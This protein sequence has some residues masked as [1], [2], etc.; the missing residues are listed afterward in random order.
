MNWTR[1]T[2]G[3]S[4]VGTGPTGAYEGNYYMY[5]ET[6]GFNNKTAV[7]ETPQFNLDTIYN[8]MVSFYYHMYGATMGDL[9]F[10]VLDN[11]A[12]VTLWSMTGEQQTA[13]ADPWRE[14]I[15]D[16]SAYQTDTTQFR[17][18]GETGTSYT[19]D[20][21]IDDFKLGGPVL[22]TKDIGVDQ[23]LN[24][25][26][27]VMAGTAMPVQLTFSNFGSDTITTAT[28]AW[29]YD[30]TLQTPY[31]YTGSLIQGAQTASMTV[32]NPTP[33]LGSHTIKAWTENPN[34]TPD[35]NFGNDSMEVTFYACANLLSGT[36]TI[37]PN[38][39]GT[40]NYTSFADAALA[41]NQC[42]INGAVT[43]NVASG[44]YNEQIKLMPIN[45]SSATNTIT[46]QSASGD[47][48]L[49]TLK[50]NANA[51]AD[52]Y[53]IDLDG[54]AYIE[55]KDMT[56]EA[57]DTIFSNVFVLENTVHDF[58]VE[59]C[60]VKATV[61]STANGNTMNL[62]SA[63]ADLGANISIQ[64][65]LMLNSAY[66]INF[67]G[68]QTG[69]TNWVI[70]NNSIHGQYAEAVKLVNSIS[71]VVTNNDIIAD[72]T[73]TYSGYEGIYLLSNTGSATIS[74]N[75]IYTKMT[76]TGYGIRMS[77]CSFDTLNPATVVNN[78][79]NLSVNS[80]GTTISAG[81]I[82][83]ESKFVNVFYNTVRMHGV[84]VNSPAMCL[85]DGT[86][87]LSKGI[88]IVNNIFTNDAN[89][90]VYYIN[91]VDT[92]LWVDHHNELFN[93]NS[94]S[95]F[96]YLLGA[97]IAN[98]TDWIDGSGSMNCVNVNPYYSSITE[99]HPAN[100]YLNDVG[101]PI[102]SV[103]DDIDGVSRNATNP[104]MGAVEF[105]ATPHDIAALELIAPYSG[106][107]LTSTESVT[108]K[109]KNIGS[110]DITSF[111]AKYQLVG[112]AT[113]VSEAVTTTIVS[114]DTLTYTFTTHVDLD[115]STIGADSSFIIMAWG[116]L[117]GDSDHTNDSTDLE[118]LSGFVPDTLHVDNDTVV[119]AYSDTL[120]VSGNNVY[121]WA[122]DTSSV[123]LANDTVF[124]TGPLYDTTTYW[125]SDRAGAGLMNVQI[126]NGTVVNAASS[127]PTPYGNWYWGNKEQYLIL[128]SELNAMGLSGGPITSIQ[129]DVTAVNSVPTLNNYE[130][131]IGQTS[132]SALST[133]IPS[134]TTVFS[135]G[136]YTASQ[137]WNEHVFSSP[138]VW[139]GVSNIVV[140]VCSNNGSYVG[141]GNASVNHT[142]TTF[143]SVLNY[144]TDGTSTICQAT[145]LSYG[146]PS[147]NRPNMKLKV[148]APGCYGDRTSF[149]VVVTNF[150]LDDAS[151]VEL[152]EPTGTVLA[153]ANTA[154]KGII[155]NFGQNVITSVDIP[156]S[157]NGVVMDTVTWSG[158]LSY[159]QVDTFL[160]DSVAFSGG[161]INLTAYTTL[162]NDTFYSN[163]TASISFLA[164][165]NGVYSIGDTT[166][167]A[168]DY[169]SF[170]GAVAALNAAGICGNV[171]FNVEAGVYEEKVVV[172]EVVGVGPNATIT[173]QAASGDST[174]V[175]I[176]DSA[177]S[178][179]NAYI[180]LLDGA[181]YVT[182]T[183]L[184]FKNIGNNYG[185]GIELISGA[186][187]NTVTNCVFDMKPT[188]YSVYCGFY[189][190]GDNN[191]LTITNNHSY[192]GGRPISLEGISGTN[193]AKGAYIGGNIID[194]F[195]YYGMR[196]SYTDSVTVTHNTITSGSN[197]NYA[198]GLYFTYNFNH[199]E[200]SYNK[201]DILVGGASTKYGMYIYAGNYYYYVGQG[202]AGATGLVYNNV[203]NLRAGTGTK[204]G[205][206]FGYNDN[207]KFY[208]NTSTVSNG[209]TNVRALHQYNSANSTN[210]EILLNNSFVDSVGGYAAYFSTPATVN[211]SDYNNFYTAG[212]SLAYWGGAKATLADLQAASGKD[213]HSINEYPL[214]MSASDL[215]L[216]S[217]N[218]SGMATPLVEVT[219]DFD[220]S[221]RSA[222]L[223]TIGFH[224][225][226][227]LNINIGVTE[228][229][230][231]P[232]TTYEATL[233]PMVAKVHNFGL[234]TV[235]QFAIE[236]AVGS[237]TPVSQLV[238]D[239]LAPN[240]T[241]SYTLASL[242][243]PAGDGT[244]CAYTVLATDSDAYNDGTC[245]DFYAIPT[246]DAVMVSIIDLEDAC[247]MGNDTVR[248]VVTNIGIDTINSS[249]QTVPTLVKYQVNGGTIVS[250][251]FTPVVAPDDT[252]TYTFATLSDFS[253][254]S[255][256]DS[257]FNIVAW[258]VFT[259][260]FV[261]SNDST[262]FELK[263]L[264]TPLSPT[265]VTPV[266][267]SYASTANLS[268][269]S[270]SNDLLSWY[271]Y[272]TSSTSIDTGAT[273]TTPT[274]FATDSFYVAA[275]GAGSETDVTIGTG[276]I[277]NHHI[278]MEMFY[279]YT[280]SQSI[281]YPTD[282]N[283]FGLI[284]KIAYYYSGNGTY[285]DAIDIFM[286]TTTNA[287]FASTSAW[288]PYADLTPV[289]SGTFTTTGTSG[290]VEI[291]L[292]NPFFYD[293]SENLVV[294]FDE[295]TPGYHSSTD[296]CLG[297]NVTG[298]RSIYFYNDGTNPDPVTPPTSGY[299]LG[300]KSVIAN[301]VFHIVPQGCSSIK[302]KVDVI[303]GTQPANDMAVINIDKPVTGIFKTSH[304]TVIVQ[305]ANYGS[306][307]Q[308]N[309]PMKY[310]INNGTV[311]VDTYIPTIT[312]GDTVSFTYAQV[313]DL[314]G[315][316]SVYNF[317]AYTDLANDATHDNDT[318][319]KSVKH[320]YP[321]YCIS[322]AN[323][324]SNSVISNVSL[325]NNFSNSS[326]DGSAVYTNFTQTVAPVDL[327]VGVATAVDI[328]TDFATG[329]SY[330]SSGY[331]KIF[332]DYNR[333]GDF[334]DANEE[335]FG[336][337]SQS[338]GN[339]LGNF[340]VPYTVLPGATAMRVVH[341][342]YGS[343]SSVTPCGTYSY[344]ETEDYYVN[345]LPR[346]PND[347]GVSLIVNPVTIA[348]T[349]NT[350]VEVEI[351]N[352][353]TDTINTVDV[354][355]V[356]NGAAPITMTYN[357]APMAPLAVV[358]LNLGSIMLQ[359][360]ANVISTYTTL[361]G[362]TNNFNDT[363][364]RSVYLQATV[365]LAYNDDFEGGD[366]WMPDTLV[367]Q[368][369]RGVPAMTNINTAHSPVNV[370]GIDLD[371]NYA[372]N[373]D[374][375]LY[376]P[377]FVTTGLDSAILDFWHYYDVLSN[378]G[379][380]VEVSID[381][382]P[383]IT[384]GLS[385]DPLG[386]N[387]YN[388][389]IGGNPFW[390]GNSAGWIN[391][392][393]KIM[394]NNTTFD[395][396]DTIQVRFYF[397]S[398]G[399]G[400]SANG[401]AIDDFSLE[402]AKI[403]QDAGVVAINSPAASVAVG[404]A[405]TVDV[406][407]KN[408]GTDTLFSIPVSYTVDGGT[409]VNGTI[410]IPAP[411]LYPD[412]VQ[413]YSFAT[414]FTAPNTDFNICAKT[415]LAGDIYNQ[416][417]ETCKQVQVTMAPIDARTVAVLV[418][419]SWNDTTKITFDNTVTVKV[420]NNGTTALTSVNLE[421]RVGSTVKGTGTWTGNLA[422]LDTLTYT[423]TDTYKSPIGYYQLCG[424]ATVTGDADNTNDEFCRNLLGVN[425][426][427]VDENE[428]DVFTVEQNQPNPAHGKVVIDFSIPQSGKVHFELRNALGQVI[429]TEE[430]DRTIGNN[431]IVIDATDLSSG[432]YYYTV[433]FDKQRITKK[434]LVNN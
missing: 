94:T 293:G 42:G 47:S 76:S 205:M 323:Y 78:F 247:N 246:K 65:N 67:V 22:L 179:S 241:K 338:S 148:D 402:L 265:V 330:N 216:L 407:V 390:S 135:P 318:T 263:S 139:D 328:T 108:I 122:S 240:A 271:R 303:V 204:Y 288:I 131:S 302:S 350:S 430:Y 388:T 95:D 380:A 434:M 389:T 123:E 173:F 359:S 415:S 391:S 428:A 30:G 262:S 341:R 81:I 19:S 417:D 158:S 105:D 231:F 321:V 362:D 264:H 296:E 52:N 245:Y 348:T 32:G 175:I 60:V 295:N 159:T 397:H 433:E 54:V 180:V 292:D 421:Y 360:G 7:I 155:K 331:L 112:S 254:G 23:I 237:G 154:V 5:T 333:D 256:A 35:F 382:G 191:Y 72:T 125:V 142:A 162:P 21:C 9:Y 408:F 184:T 2:G 304:D 261:A 28:V 49:V 144:H 87:G 283:E 111:T 322:K 136:S 33:V 119:Y 291:T 103:T 392:T 129:F 194:G 187:H 238:N 51:M 201:I 171:V 426:V 369:E 270:P 272:D 371:D 329:S 310:S 233:I 312:S 198:Y 297:T 174:D 278:P 344:G 73:S 90:Y 200:V 110:A 88:T 406:D 395:Y 166:T 70:N 214:T 413:T 133:W 25:T 134:L 199:F 230:N 146:Y 59:N 1:K 121:W 140:Q 414:G 387:W 236:Y 422:S 355:Y 405:V 244:L 132:V 431:Q 26:G 289:Y 163:D 281:Y 86:A 376:T 153:G 275:S 221:V 188:T 217:Y 419:P 249:V 316:D 211:V 274:L 75:S 193:T 314:S 186:D 181:D 160:L 20:M 196:V 91:N 239:T 357:T 17:F 56:F 168:F 165:L 114:G 311:V 267:I 16:V 337:S 176:L 324:T 215:H 347:A 393:Y 182:F 342:I 8:P 352:Y 399:S 97:T 259:G 266:N 207:V 93:Y 257:V 57:E 124:V 44:T 345:I 113:A 224:E 69:A 400:N 89:G 300:L 62:I 251:T 308:S 276:S 178:Y 218:L 84:Q 339:V 373:S 317:V 141:S 301:T 130:I 220:G 416:N 115:V 172:E 192:G 250:E 83:H 315:V 6:S 343:A 118:V 375:Y 358:S 127:Y 396:P 170:N 366:I 157:I 253:T 227:M 365:N 82:N 235:Y 242:T 423:F 36:Y 11:G 269:T 38:G 46:F 332:I 10:E 77:S 68:A 102:A 398:N 286:G 31:S 277:I 14:A 34:G 320:E 18:R 228:V 206:Y 71:A 420:V 287:V 41:L 101:T 429:V 327:Q 43:F 285:S 351:M 309:I 4:S 104:D 79:V 401:W 385:N 219:D 151:L 354:S 98:Y 185:I 383:W 210:G 432:V 164:C 403:A 364:S 363:L 223:P 412:S 147:T 290:W 280:Y 96:A 109:Y 143:N 183:N 306:A 255:A 335:V 120:S 370:W 378:D 100:N 12:W 279:G 294:A 106:C 340:S 229:V 361:V 3:T 116:E 213:A 40:T 212:T 177:T 128:A 190:H 234:D 99:Y 197:C 202:T 258:I 273:Y 138:F 336:S 386:T 48:S 411:G 66:A 126:G 319:I 418:N 252:T 222:V 37:D 63:D 189:S 353:G 346:I 349:A 161:L 298:N 29:S 425:N 137:G 152:I 203:V 150:P 326:T 384:L 45:G 145:N 377:R 374:D 260:D 334:T 195:G 394:L 379:G 53:V 404:S 24:P 307:D 39:S 243:A 13:N 55:F 15:V 92:S 368:W 282:F 64:N 74:K 58:A 225:K 209:G 232:D 325:G 169:G 313:A 27:G 305:V 167:G 381:N 268:A 149:T 424:K 372:N 226:T 284:T 299:S 248:V 356:L 80:T 61:P 409:P 85:F 156:Y 50:Y 367:N 208:Y 427:G 410:T 117:T 107:G